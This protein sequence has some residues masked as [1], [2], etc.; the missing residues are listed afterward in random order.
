M[1]H[2]LLNAGSLPVFVCAGAEPA[3]QVAFLLGCH[4]VMSHGLALQSKA[5]KAL[6]CTRPLPRRLRTQGHP[7]AARCRISRGMGGGRG[8]LQRPGRSRGLRSHCRT[9][10][11]PVGPWARRHHRCGVGGNAAPL[12]LFPRHGGGVG[13][14]L[15]WV[16]S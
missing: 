6:P 15:E 16:R 14:R 3:Q 2:T 4:L 9:P 7:C 5:P 10:M 8:G 12:V 1:H 13:L 11:R